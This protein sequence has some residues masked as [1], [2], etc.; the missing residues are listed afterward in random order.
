VIGVPTGA[1]WFCREAVAW[2]G[3]DHDVESVLVAA[4]VRGWIRERTDDL[5]LLDDRT[6]PTV[7]D[8]HRQR[9]FVTRT[10]VDEVN[11]QPIDV[12]RELRQGIQLRF[13][14][15]PVVAVAPVLNQP[16]QLR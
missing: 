6:R 4:A 5:E 9:I 15:A 2:Q 11:V 14:L 3:R 10:D 7:R 1:G 16:L 8:Y 13:Y 12:R